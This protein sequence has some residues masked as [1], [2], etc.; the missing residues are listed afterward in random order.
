MIFIHV[1]VELTKEIEAK[2][3]TTQRDRNQVER[4]QKEETEETTKEITPRKDTPPE[5][6]TQVENPKEMIDSE[7]LKDMRKRISKLEKDV[8]TISDKVDKVQVSG[9]AGA[10]NID[11]LVSKYNEVQAEMEKLNQT[12]D[13]LIDDRETREMHLNVS[14]LF[15]VFILIVTFILYRSIYN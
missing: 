14:I 3:L 10:T 2:Q 6:R 4:T 8:I 9:V 7:E 1:H 11:N 12:A 13:R 5:P 15:I